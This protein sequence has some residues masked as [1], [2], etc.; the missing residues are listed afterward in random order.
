MY[1]LP[2][3]LLG[4]WTIPP[5]PPPLRMWLL[6]EPLATSSLPL[7]PAS[8]VLLVALAVALMEALLVERLVAMLGSGAS[9]GC[10]GCGAGG[11]SSPSQA[12]AV[13][14]VEAAQS[15]GHS[16]KSPPRIQDKQDVVKRTL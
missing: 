8:P 14:G 4:F 10:R 2:H 1:W 16:G 6:L 13:V 12:V 5:N 3:V 7:A 11:P 9:G 15:A